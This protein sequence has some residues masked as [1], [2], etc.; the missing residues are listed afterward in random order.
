MNEKTYKEL[1][2]QENWLF[3]TENGSVIYTNTIKRFENVKHIEILDFNP[4]WVQEFELSR[5][6]LP[7]LESILIAILVDNSGTDYSKLFQAI[8]V[9]SLA[10]VTQITIN[11]YYA[12]RLPDW[13]QFCT[14]LKC[15][16][17]YSSRCNLK[18]LPAWFGQLKELEKFTTEG[19]S[20]DQIPPQI[21][22]FVNIKSLCFNRGHRITVIPDEIKKLQKLTELSIWETTFSYVS[23]ELFR[24][25]DLKHLN[26]YF[27]QYPDIPPDTMEAIISLQREKPFIKIWWFREKD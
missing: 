25:P 18:E 17:F 13:I 9:N 23:P 3:D 27:S 15:L 1:Q 14:G 11:D 12:D 10:K 16:E 22:D 19:V 26:F 5:P 6:E 8:D 7:A 20:Y 24:L 2:D 4:E 21:F